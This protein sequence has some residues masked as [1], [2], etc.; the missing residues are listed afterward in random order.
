VAVGRCS[1]CLQC[2]ARCKLV[3]IT[4]QKHAAVSVKSLKKNYEGP[5]RVYA[6]AVPHRAVRVLEPWAWVLGATS[7]GE[8]DRL[9][10]FVAADA[11]NG[12]VQGG[13]RP[14]AVFLCLVRKVFDAFVVLVALMPKKE[15]SPHWPLCRTAAVLTKCRRQPKMTQELKLC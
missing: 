4:S 13:Q 1:C 6:P 15:G 3:A 9:V 14:A 5:E 12:V 10:A 11:R 7:F 2:H 8:R